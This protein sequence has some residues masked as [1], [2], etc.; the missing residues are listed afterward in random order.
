[1]VRPPLWNIRYS[2]LLDDPFQECAFAV[3]QKESSAVTV[4]PQ[5]TYATCCLTINLAQLSL[6]DG[7]LID[8]GVSEKPQS[9]GSSL[10]SSP[11]ATIDAK[12]TGVLDSASTNGLNEV[13]EGSEDSFV[14]SGESKENVTGVRETRV[15]DEKSTEGPS[16][17]RRRNQTNVD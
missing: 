3:T 14:V 11:S 5:R 6:N 15:L 10:L 4:L 9:N 13:E 17:K 12:S 8:S 7:E 2:S 1:M 16:P